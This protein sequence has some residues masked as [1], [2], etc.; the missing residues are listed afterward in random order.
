V[1]YEGMNSNGDSSVVWLDPE[2][3]FPV[4]SQGKNGGGELHN[5]QEGAQPSNL[6]EVPA[7]FNKMDMG[8]MMQQR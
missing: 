5:I 2:L 1:K 8:G 4:K 6:F 3:R 7:G